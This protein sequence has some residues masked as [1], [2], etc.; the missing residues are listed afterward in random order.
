MLNKVIAWSLRNRWLVLAA[1]LILLVLGGRK[2]AELPIDVFPDITAPQVTIL[3]E[4]PGMSPQEVE[5]LVSFPIEASIN[6]A[7]N[8]TAVRSSSAIGLSVVTVTFGYGTNIYIARQLVSEKLQLALGQLPEGVQPPVMG[9]IS[10]R[11]GEIMTFGMTS[12]KTSAMDLRTLADWTVRTRLLSVPGVSQ[13]IVIGGDRKQYQVLVDPAKLRAYDITLN[14]VFDAVRESNVNA[15]GGFLQTPGQES[16]IRGI[17][18]VTSLDDLD[19]TVI[20]TRGGGPVLLRQV[21]E[22]RL[23]PELKR[24]DA[25]LNGEKAIL[26]TISRQP[27]ANTL[28]LTKRVDATLDELQHTLPSD[29]KLERRVYRQAAFIDRAIKNVESAISEGGILVTII[30]FLFLLNFRT[31][32]ISLTAIP[33]SLVVAILVLSWFGLSINTMTLGGLAIA[34]GALVDD[35]IIDVENVFRRLKENHHRPPGERTNNLA[36]VYEASAEIRNSIVFATYIIVLVFA[37]LF[38]LSGIEGKMFT[39]LGVAYIIAI[40]A[41]LAVALTITP[42]LCYFL[43]GRERFLAK[44]EEET[45]TYRWLKA[46]YAPVLRL[47]LRRP[48]LVLG[49]AL[50]LLIVALAILPTLGKEFLPPFIEGS[51][52]VN[53]LLQP[54]TSLQES[55]RIGRIVEQKLLKHPEIVVTGR[56]TGRAELSEDA[57]GVQYNEIEVE[58]RSGKGLRPQADLVASLRKDLAQVPGASLSIGQPLSHRIE[59]MLSGTRAQLAISLYGPDLPVLRQKAEEIRRVAAGTPGVAD[60]FVEQQ[61]L[62]PQVQIA[63]DRAAAARY[64]LRPGTISQTIQ[65]AFN[66]S[67][68]SQV[69]EGQATFDLIVWTDSTSRNNIDL[70]RSLLIDTPSGTKIPIAQVAQVIQSTGPNQITREAVQRKIV[71]Q[72]NVQGRDLSGFVDDLRG[73]IA[74]QVQLPQGYYLQ[75][76]GQFEQQARAQRQLLSLGGVSLV[77][78]FLLLFL[79]FGS[80]RAAL[81]VLSNLPLAV[82]GGIFAVYFTNKTISVAS[83]VGFI[84]LFGIATRNGIMMVTHYIHLRAEGKPWDEVV[85]QGSMER[86]N[87]VLM[88]A[89]VASIGLVP[90][91]LR[92]GQ[93]GT[94]L[95]YPL[96]VVIL[97]GMVTATP[98]TLLVIPALYS[99]FIAG[100]ER[101]RTVDPVLEPTGTPASVLAT[102]E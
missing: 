5:A 75:Y 102:R 16:I 59:H 8:V 63:I 4:A 100:R 65:T 15:P 101:A 49:G 99:R 1:G 86:L 36:V 84:T 3:T 64:G 68:A 21:A 14:Q 74:Q 62:V 53:V 7:A 52:T 32:L 80:L 51:L 35:A 22:V 85:W 24:G 73:R 88:T 55:E 9:P 12:T 98:L 18:R 44:H 37:P 89:L 71:I 60:L 76:G 25:G 43:L 66:G 70:I 81:L 30:L 93:P 90:L 34:I 77:V 42:V 11:L 2:I 39:P 79:A 61:T 27:T 95:Q 50:A 45:W 67:V 87:P 46:R 13:V 31:T 96:A 57:E 54:G 92:A 91:A 10:S 56:R 20:A 82:I 48:F 19:N 69:L 23:G 40:I 72:S 28:E 26:V 41:S 29:V 94:E 17:G 58:L 78:I 47:S 33:F 83:I 6:G 97:G 38:V